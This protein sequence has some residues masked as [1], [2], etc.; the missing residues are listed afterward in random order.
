MWTNNEKKDVS[1]Y[2]NN[3]C[4]VLTTW[5]SPQLELFK[6]IILFIYLFIYL[7]ILSVVKKCEL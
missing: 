7:F 5:R 1:R 4:Q 3:R 6:K 2:Q